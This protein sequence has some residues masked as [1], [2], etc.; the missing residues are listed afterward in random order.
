MRNAH[1][2]IPLFIVATFVGAC[3]QEQ[4]DQNIVITNNSAGAD[5]EALPPDE[6]STTP[7][8]E[9]INGNDN[10]EVADLNSA[11]NSY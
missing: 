4:S 3:Q 6:S 2:L 1:K 5:I 9:L 11:D 8:D 7:T 10:A